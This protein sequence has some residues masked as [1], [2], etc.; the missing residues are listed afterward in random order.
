[1]AVTVL[2]G[3]PSAGNRSETGLLLS[4]SNWN[5]TGA[6]E[7]VYPNFFASHVAD[8]EAEA[9]CQEKE[10]NVLMP[11]CCCTNNLL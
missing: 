7:V 5:S 1:V 10:V 11:M 3:Y 2:V 8:L 4:K 9:Y 6:G